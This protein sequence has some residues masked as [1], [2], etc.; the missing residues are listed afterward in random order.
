MVEASSGKV[1]GLVAP[2][3]SRRDAFGSSQLVPGTTLQSRKGLFYGT[4]QVVIRDRD[5]QQQRQGRNEINLVDGANLG[6]RR[7]RCEFRSGPAE[8]RARRIHPQGCFDLVIALAAVITFFVHAVIAHDDEN[9]VVLDARGKVADEVIHLAELLAHL[10]VI[11]A[12]AVAGM[13]DAEAVAD[14]QVPF[15]LPPE[16]R[17]YV[18]QHA[19]VDR[20]KVPDIE[21]VVGSAHVGLE[22]AGKQAHPGVI[23][24]VDDTF[25]DVS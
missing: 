11:R 4:P 6:S 24:D 2:D 22:V 3:A 5:A 25:S 21:A 15:V 20:V 7:W 23:S 19:V 1:R 12:V 16:G 18:L 17:E 8:R 13:V 10:L 9:R 14:E